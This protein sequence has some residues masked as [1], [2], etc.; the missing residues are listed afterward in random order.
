ML[1]TKKK[2]STRVLK[3]SET[4]RRCGAVEAVLMDALGIMSGNAVDDVM[5]MQCR[6]GNGWPARSR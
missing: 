4:V 2:R 6:G 3:V 1:K 5:D